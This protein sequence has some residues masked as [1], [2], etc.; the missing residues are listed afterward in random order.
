MAREAQE[1]AYRT[2]KY[3]DVDRVGS[4]GGEGGEADEDDA[5]YSGQTY[6]PTALLHQPGR[7][8]TNY[9]CR[10]HCFVSAGGPTRWETIPCW[11]PTRSHSP[12]PSPWTLSWAPCTSSAKPRST[13]S[14]S[15]LPERPSSRTMG[16]NGITSSIVLCFAHLKYWSH[17]SWI[18][19]ASILA[20]CWITSTT[21]SWTC[22]TCC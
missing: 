20:V 1:M 13:S 18:F 22:S 3:G 12:M 5:D 10:W 19:I 9:S 17:T 11:G 16:L 6:M 15:V 21:H 4:K 2:S 8:P 7:V 14:R